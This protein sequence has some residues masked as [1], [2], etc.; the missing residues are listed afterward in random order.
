MQIS[1]II[2]RDRYADI[3]ISLAD[4]RVCQCILSRID[5]HKAPL[6]GR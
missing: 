2:M 4:A 6:Q 1:Q 3:P 5:A